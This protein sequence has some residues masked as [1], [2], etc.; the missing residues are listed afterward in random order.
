MKFFSATSCTD[1]SCMTDKV[2][3]SGKTQDFLWSFGVNVSSCYTTFEMREANEI[4]CFCLFE[5]WRSTVLQCYSLWIILRCL[6]KLLSK[7]LSMT[8]QSIHLNEYLS[9]NLGWKCV[10]GLQVS[11]IYALVLLEHP[12]IEFW[13]TACVSRYKF[14]IM[15][16]INIVFFSFLFCDISPCHVLALVCLDL[17]ALLVSLNSNYLKEKFHVFIR[18]DCFIKCLSI[19]R[20]YLYCFYLTPT[21]GRLKKKMG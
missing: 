9:Q 7:K 8:M 10:F 17:F 21:H 5:W 16:I 15:F 6:K 1:I 13:A 19:I 3:C 2:N 20:K 18:V 11:K 14:S 4:L 12:E